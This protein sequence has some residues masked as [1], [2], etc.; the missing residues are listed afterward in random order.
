M[1][2]LGFGE[3]GGRGRVGTGRDVVDAGYAPDQAVGGVV[4]WS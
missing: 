2:V 3:W 1:L 4:D